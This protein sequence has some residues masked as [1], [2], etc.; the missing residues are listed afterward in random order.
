[1]AESAISSGTAGSSSD[2]A[3][4]T[5]AIATG[6]AL[7]F[8]AA[9]SSILLQVSKNPPQVQTL[10]YSGPSLS[11][12]VNKFKPQEIIEASVPSETESPSSV[13]TDNSAAEVPQIQVKSQIQLQPSTPGVESIF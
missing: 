11:Y 13:P 5:A 2:G 4:N 6:L 8:V 1:V 12:Y 9:A 3:E 10:E 7:I